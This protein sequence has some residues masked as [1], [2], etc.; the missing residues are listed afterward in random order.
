[1][2]PDSQSIQERSNNKNKTK[3][4]A[5][6]L[7]LQLMNSVNCMVDSV[8]VQS[9]LRGDYELQQVVELKQL[10]KQSVSKGLSKKSHVNHCLS[11]TKA[12]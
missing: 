1:M 7:Q 6:Q 11:M 10:E 3:T 5:K 2:E 12:S 9:H 8:S 4:T